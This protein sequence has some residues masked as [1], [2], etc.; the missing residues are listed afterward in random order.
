[1]GRHSGSTAGGSHMGLI[2]PSLS[3]SARLP[4]TVP[5]PVASGALGR[6]SGGGG[7]SGSSG[8]GG[9]NGLGAGAG[10]HHF[11]PVPP[12]AAS[13]GPVA[14]PLPLSSASGV[15]TAPTGVPA[16]PPPPTA[17]ATAGGGSAGARARAPPSRRA[18]FSAPQ[19]PAAPR[20]LTPAQQL[21][22]TRQ[23][24]QA[25]AAWAAA[26]SQAQQS[27]QGQLQQ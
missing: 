9:G 8:G 20:V 23:L 4:P 5:P 14:S 13:T 11:L 3:G 19:R 10:G 17:G 22:L 16:P 18:T 12:L 2:Q 21:A 24:Q 27:S 25:E 1:M 6:S 26:Q 7:A 15:I